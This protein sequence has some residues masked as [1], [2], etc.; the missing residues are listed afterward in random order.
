MSPQTH[1]SFAEGQIWLVRFVI[2]CNKCA[3]LIHFRS[4][5]ALYIWVTYLFREELFVGVE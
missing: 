1:G 4:F 2:E 5:L 3:L